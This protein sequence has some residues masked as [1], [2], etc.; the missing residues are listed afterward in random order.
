MI[1]R[2]ES[3][4]MKGV[5]ILF[6]VLHNL[7]HMISNLGENEF[8]YSSDRTKL[9]LSNLFSNADTVWMDI[10]SFLGWYGVPT[11][12][13]LSGY[14]LVKKYEF[15]EAKLN[16]IQYIWAH[17]WKLFTLMLLPYIFYIFLNVTLE[18]K[19]ISC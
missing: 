17:F 11:F 9:F 3:E 15:A 6:I 4:E 7:L 14:G 16:F 18:G 19:D 10:F 1:T 8:F 2:N 5:A 12:I 13:F